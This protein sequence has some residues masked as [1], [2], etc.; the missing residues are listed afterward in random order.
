MGRMMFRDDKN[1]RP[2]SLVE[3]LI[4]L[5]LLAFALSLLIPAAGTT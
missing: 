5:A 2:I 4:I 3:R 1:A